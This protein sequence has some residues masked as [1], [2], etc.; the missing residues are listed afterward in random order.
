MV[1]DELVKKLHD[2]NQRFHE[3]K[4]KLQGSVESVDYDHQD[5]YQRQFE[6]VR[7][8]ESEIEELEKKIR[9]IVSRK[10]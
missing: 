9:E 1:P 5:H 8:M 10:P 3:A 4:G 2:A 7:K 6:E